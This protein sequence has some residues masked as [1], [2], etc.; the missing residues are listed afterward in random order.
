MNYHFVLHMKVVQNKIP[1]NA[2]DGSYPGF[3]MRYPGCVL[4]LYRNLEVALYLDNVGYLP[5]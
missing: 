4:Y 3:G 1:S 2:I 5:A